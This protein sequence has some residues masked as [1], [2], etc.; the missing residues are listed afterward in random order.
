VQES[1]R[2]LDRSEEPCMKCTS[3]GHEKRE[4]T[5]RA[6]NKT[7][8]FVL[9]C[10]SSSQHSRRTYVKYAFSRLFLDSWGWRLAEPRSL[11]SLPG[12]VLANEARQW[13][14]RHALIMAENCQAMRKTPPLGYRSQHPTSRH[15]D[16]AHLDRS[17][18][19]LEV[20]REVIRQVNRKQA[21]SK[22]K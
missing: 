5:R 6:P 16:Q 13:N 12:A 17:S 9:Y 19:V 22:F 11:L 18:S 7:Q 8:P 3:G 4:P 2:H 21:S 20:V 1:A 15:L 14:C 10:V